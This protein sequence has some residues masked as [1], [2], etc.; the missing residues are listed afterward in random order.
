MLSRKRLP[1]FALL[2]F[3]LLSV[4]LIL[5]GKFDLERW[6]SNALVI[7]GIKLYHSLAAEC[8]EDHSVAVVSGGMCTNETKS[9]YFYVVTIDELESELP[10]IL[11][12]GWEI[13]GAM[14]YERWMHHPSR[15]LDKSR[16]S[17][18]VFPPFLTNELNWPMYGGGSWERN[19]ARS[20]VNPGADGDKAGT[21]SIAF[22][23][24]IRTQYE[25]QPK[26]RYLLHFGSCG[27]DRGYALPP[28]A[29]QDER[30]IIAKGNALHDR[31]R[32]GIDISLPPPF[33]DNYMR[34]RWLPSSSKTERSVLLAFKGDLGTHSLRREAQRALHNPDQGILILDKHDTTFEYWELLSKTVFAPVIRGH[35]SFSYRFSE[36]VCSGA[37]PVLLAD[38]W[39][40]PFEDILP[41][42]EYGVRVR[43]AQVNELVEILSQFDAA[44]RIKLSRRAVSFCQEYLI[45]PWHQ[46]DGLMQIALSRV[47]DFEAEGLKEQSHAT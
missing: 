6:D 31:Y 19:F 42:K 43:E 25:F 1:V 38:D 7:N 10:S 21:C 8:R 44:S 27:W 22:E 29:Y 37:I 14:S 32:K 13:Y 17:L 40:P 16:A 2:I 12:C 24:F 11:G 30:A 34:M 47:V 18:V 23:N 36:V 28:E 4:S 5:K 39:V 33:T 9:A 46:F 45:S 35:V 26:Q 41:F 3:T 15:T 20:G